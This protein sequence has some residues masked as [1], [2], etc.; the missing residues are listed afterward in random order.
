MRVRAFSHER[1]EWADARLGDV[2][3]G[4]QFVAHNRLHH[5]LRPDV[6]AEDKLLDVAGI[7]E[8]DRPYD[9]RR[10]SRTPKSRDV[11][12]AFGADGRPLGHRLLANLDPG[13]QCVFQGL[14]YHIKPGP[15]PGT[16][17]LVGYGEVD[18]R[19]DHRP[20]VWVE[21]TI[22]DAL[23]VAEVGYRYPAGRR[24]PLADGTDVPVEALAVGAAFLLEEGG[25]ATATRVGVPRR[26]EPNREVRDA[27]GN[28]FRRVVGT[29]KFTGW[30]PLMSVTVGGETHRVTPGHRYWSETRRGWYPIGTFAV[31]ELLRTK[32]NRPIPVERIVPPG[33]EHTTVYNFEVDEYHTY[34]V[35]RGTTAVWS[36]NGLGGAGCGV[37]KAATPKGARGPASGREFDPAVA[38]GPIRQL[39]TD[40]IKVTNRGIDAVERHVS[41]FGPDEANQTMIQRLRDIAGGR[42]QATQADK[43]FYAHEL[44]ESVRYR[45]LGWR[46]GQPAAPDAARTL[47]NNAHTATLEDYRLRE[48]PGVLYHPSIPW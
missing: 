43:N 46:D 3:P 34:F 1:R 10:D 38:G 2:K 29:F 31:G 27:H 32:E 20:Y 22:Q 21:Y 14:V 35:G 48:G 12:Y 41:R 30:V 26:W 37:P 42:I 11:V 18:H 36:H 5:V 24:I 23:G 45:R 44:R 25:T 33:W 47:W 28:G 19:P 17:T 15:T 13:Q 40:R 39:S 4:Q 9:P 7:P 6:Y 16:G 8:A